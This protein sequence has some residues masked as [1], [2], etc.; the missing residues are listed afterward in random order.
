MHTV[1]EAL[2]IKN[3]NYYTYQPKTEKKFKIVIKW[4]HAKLGAKYI[5]RPNGKRTQNK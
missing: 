3:S 2:E 5:D 1:I 4:L